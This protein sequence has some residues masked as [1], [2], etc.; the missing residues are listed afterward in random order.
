MAKTKSNTKSG[1]PQQPT[2]TSKRERELE[3]RA[4]EAEFAVKVYEADNEKLEKELDAANSAYLHNRKM[5]EKAEKELAECKAGLKEQYDW[6]INDMSY[7]A[8]ELIPSK[9][10]TVWMPVI[11]KAVEDSL[12]APQP[13]S[14][15]ET[16]QQSPVEGEEL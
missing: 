15:P 7:T 9:M 4:E 16:N 2:T 10:A 3:Q 6:V 14:K 11:M 12:T 13:P 5:R 8:P 1:T